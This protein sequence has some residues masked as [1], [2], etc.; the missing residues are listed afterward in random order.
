MCATKTTGTRATFQQADGSLV[1]DIKRVDV[2]DDA[3]K[4]VKVC[5]HL[6]G[7]LRTDAL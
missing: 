7:T 6:V 1:T 4:A 2:G 5:R 3:Y